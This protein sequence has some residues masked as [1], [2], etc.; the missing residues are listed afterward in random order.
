MKRLL[1][2]TADRLLTREEQVQLRELRIN[3]ENFYENLLVLDRVLGGIG[4]FNINKGDIGR[5]DVRDREILR[6]FQYIDAYFQM[7]HQH[8]SW[9]TRE[10]V[11][12]C[13]LHLESMIKNMFSFSRMPLGQALTQWVVSNRLD[14]QLMIDLRVIVGL[15]NDAK[16]RVNHQKDTHLFD[17]SDAL[18]CYIVTRKISMRLMPMVRLYTPLE[19][20]E[21]C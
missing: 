9:V 18:V 17:I 13:G 21:G 7:D 5:Y 10:I 12:M 6:P 14:N 16:H 2:E 3:I 20:W 11:H 15:Y 19:V 8:V 4:I 1:F